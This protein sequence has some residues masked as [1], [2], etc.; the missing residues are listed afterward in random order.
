MKVSIL[1][2]C[3]NEAN[4]IVEIVDKV[5]ASP[6]N[7]E[8]EIIIVDDGSTDNVKE[9]LENELKAR[10][11]KIIYHETNK[12]KG[13]AINTGL[14]YVTGDILIIQDA[15]LEY[16]PSDYP[17]LIEPIKNGSADVVYGSR[18][19]TKENRSLSPYW[20]Y[21]GN[22]LLTIISNIFSGLNLTDM[23]TCYKAIS[24]KIYQK[25]TIQEKAFGIEP[26]ITAKLAKLNAVIG[27]VSI[28]YHGRSY[29]EGKKIT[30]QDG[31]SAL[32]CILKYNL[33]P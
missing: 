32:R 19:L 12:G 14:K 9:I 23:E 16:D 27:E 17:K 6:L 7:E 25:L 28:T 4:T 8:K 33:F 26:E 1:I 11:S 24:K 29:S 10:V 30:W 15:D 18:F 20:H 22:K 2:P 3:F 21:L 31:V 13:S 5:H